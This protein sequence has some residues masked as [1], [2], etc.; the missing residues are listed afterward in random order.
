MVLF[1]GASLDILGDSLSGYSM[2]GDAPLFGVN[3]F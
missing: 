2:S 3:L 1:N